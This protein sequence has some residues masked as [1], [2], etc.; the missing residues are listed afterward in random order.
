MKSRDIAADRD[1]ALARA[2]V[3]DLLAQVFAYPEDDRFSDLQNLARLIVT[4]G[5]WVPIVRLA[6]LARELTPERLREEYS[7]ALS[8]NSSP[9]C[10]R[11]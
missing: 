8:L 10:P 1:I 11:C 2:V 5:G 4:N 9:D 6:A 7:S 3:Y